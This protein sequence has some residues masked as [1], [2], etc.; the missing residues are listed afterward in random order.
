[1]FSACEEKIDLDLSYAGQKPVVEGR[2][3][4]EVDSSYIRLTQ[5]APYNS[6]EAPKTITNAVVEM[7][8]DNEP[9]VVFSH[10]GNGIYKPAAGYVGEANHNYSLKVVIDGKEYTSQSYLYPMFDVDTTVTQEFKKA[11]AFFDDGYT[12]TFFANYNQPPIKYYW[13]R[14]GKNDSLEDGDVLFDNSTIAQYTV[15]PFEL[16]FF[17]AQKEDSVMMIFRTVDVNVYNYLY[18]LGNLTGGA[19]GLFQAPPANP[20]TNI[21]GNA[22]GFFYTSD[23]VRRWLVVK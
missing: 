19:P 10:V 18:A 14:Y 16:P 2:V 22:L 5:T 6:N 23:V 7:V 3:T 4:T 13:F 1:L 20:P 8:K 15:R 11:D 9:S 12:I 17:R 21:K